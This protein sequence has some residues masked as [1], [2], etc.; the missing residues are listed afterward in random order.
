V[1]K[2]SA[3]IAPARWQA[4][5]QGFG[6]ASPA[7]EFA[8]LAT[9]YAEPHRHYHTAQHIS[10]CLAH[11]DAARGLCDHPGEVE[12]AIWFH[13]A[14]Y[15]PRAKDNEEM[16]AQWAR[17]V[18]SDAGIEADAGQRVS[19]LIMA[20]R[21]ATPPDTADGQIMVDIDLSILGADS[22]RFNEYEEQVRGEYDWV[23]LPVFRTRRREIL[24][25]FLAREAIYATVD[26]R[27]RLEEKAREN[28]AR[29][30]AKLADE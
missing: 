11:F 23:P 29:S 13:D 20:T 8:A 12:L 10:E 30:I 4:L 6:L 9:R 25:G 21:H 18:M 1:A 27:N 26:F 24:Q 16:S 15:D 5:W 22:A 3:S 17:R 14:I 2:V 28:L 19:E 7:D